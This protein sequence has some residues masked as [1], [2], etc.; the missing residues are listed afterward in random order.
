MSPLSYPGRNRP[1]AASPAESVGRL[2]DDSPGLERLVRRVRY[3]ETVDKA[4]QQLLGSALAGRCRVANISHDTLV[5]QTASAAWGS[6]LRFLAP[7]LLEQLSRQLGWN[8]IKHTKVQVRPEAFPE[9]EQPTRR[10][11]LSRESATLLRK[12]AENTED[13]GLRDALLRLS[14]RA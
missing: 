6:R 12:V 14:R 7:R 10:A 11:H 1:P 3:L 8:R 2:C 9:H 4:L 5:L 13:P